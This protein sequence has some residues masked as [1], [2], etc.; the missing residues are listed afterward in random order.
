LFWIRDRDRLGQRI[1]E[2]VA[3]AADERG[4]P[5]A[6]R[7]NNPVTAAVFFNRPIS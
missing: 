6:I 2:D 7:I 1:F 4:P 5:A 3:G